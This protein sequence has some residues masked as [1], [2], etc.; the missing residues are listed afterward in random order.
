MLSGARFLYH[1]TQYCAQPINRPTIFTTDNK[2]LLT[3]IRR[4]IEYDANFATATVAPDW[5][6]VEDLHCALSHF[7]L[8]PEFAH[9]EGYQDDNKSYD[10]LTLT[11]QLNVDADHEA[12]NF[13]WNH[14][15]N[16]RDLVPLQP[17]HS[18]PTEY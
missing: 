15:P 14:V 7:K 3:R 9:V 5:Y 4:R 1:L 12:G 16:L 11:A 2:G 13:Q 10:K 8:P 18:C 6:L 17:S